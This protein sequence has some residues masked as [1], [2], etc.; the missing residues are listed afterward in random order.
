MAAQKIMIVDDNPANLKVL[1]EML[2]H[3]GYEVWSVPRGRLAL[4]VASQN[5]PDLILLDVRMP[6]LTGYE[7]CEQL[8]SDARLS[9]IPVIFL[10]ALDATEDK[11][12]GFRSGGVDYISKPFQFE[13][14]YA[15]VE[16]HLKLHDLQQALTLQNEHLEETVASRTRELGKAHARLAMLDRAKDDFLK[17]IS[18]EFR[19]PLS[20]VLGVGELALGELSASVENNELR[21]MFEQSRQRILSLLD[22]ALLLTEIDVSGGQF[23]SAPV[24][25]SAALVRAIELTTEFAAFRHVTLDPPNADLGL[26][27]GEEGLLVRA[28]HALLETAV[29]FSQEGG[30]VRL[31]HEVIPDSPRVIIESHGR[32]IPSPAIAKFFNIFSISE[33]TPPGEDLGLRPALACRI[34]SLFGG[35]VTVVNCDPPGI[36][37]TV[38]F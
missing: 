14:V 3:K 7:V 21:Y 22:D 32:T 15:R 2:R 17:V 20:G 38:A 35:T 6:E 19:T 25:L 12:K 37:L 5:P 9:P 11:M 23:K 26:V 33:G 29:K 10:S 18:H 31:P 27:H 8:K 34:L 30:T 16:I 4:E 24:S 13:E 28:L 1:E 36:R